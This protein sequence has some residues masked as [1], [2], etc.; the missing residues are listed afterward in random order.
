MQVQRRFKRCG[1]VFL[2]R[3]HRLVRIPPA[4]L[5]SASRQDTCGAV[6]AEQTE[7]AVTSRHL[8]AVQR[9]LLVTAYLMVTAHQPF[10]HTPTQ[11]MFIR[12]FQPTSYQCRDAIRLLH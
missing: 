4:P 6:T 3:L 12:G 11:C 1:S 10:N 9:V 7:P 5:L 2:W 8:Q